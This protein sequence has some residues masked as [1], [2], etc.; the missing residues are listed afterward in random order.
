MLTASNIHEW[1]DAHQGQPLAPQVATQSMPDAGM[2]A[3][4]GLGSRFDC[5]SMGAYPSTEVQD[6]VGTCQA[7]MHTPYLVTDE[8]A[9]IVR[10]RPQT[11]R[12]AYSTTGAFLGV[13]PKKVG[14]RLLWPR[15]ALMRLIEEGV[16]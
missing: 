3:K 12:K 14:R 11:L 9:F 10:R 13:V 7:F 6:G 8:A 15:D 5:Q 16:Q 1:G 4:G 2:L